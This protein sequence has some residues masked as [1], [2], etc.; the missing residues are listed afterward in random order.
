MDSKTDFFRDATIE[1]VRNK[2]IMVHMDLCKMV[3]KRAELNKIVAE[4][5]KRL[6]DL[7]AEINRL[8]AEIVEC[9]G[10][11]DHCEVFLL[12][13][14]RAGATNAVSP[15]HYINTEIEEGEE[16]KDEVADDA[17]CTI[18]EE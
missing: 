3:Q 1:R 10:E 16:G 18:D 4:H 7:E 6:A 14:T 12:G 9:R 17:D 15:I 8:T 11:I 2:I 13:A 5:K